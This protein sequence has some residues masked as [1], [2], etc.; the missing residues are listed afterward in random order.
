MDAPGTHVRTVFLTGHPAFSASRRKRL[1]PRQSPAYSA[2][3]DHPPARRNT[4]NLIKHMEAV[5]VVAISLA[6]SGSY[7]LDVIPEAHA[8][9]YSADSAMV[10]SDGKVAVVTVSAKRLTQEEKQAIGARG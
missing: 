1:A 9:S 5:F 7:L 6:V 4:M 3:I 2:H 8:R 10:A